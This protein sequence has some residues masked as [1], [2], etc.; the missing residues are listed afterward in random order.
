MGFAG[1]TDMGYRL[2]STLPPDIRS[3]Y[4][5]TFVNQSHEPQLEVSTT[6]ASIEE[7]QKNGVLNLA[8]EAAADSRLSVTLT[9]VV[10]EPLRFNRQQ[11]K[12]TEE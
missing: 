5:P 8:G 6:R 11:V 9:D 1:C 10:L 4:V 7:V 2:G 12:T 3:V